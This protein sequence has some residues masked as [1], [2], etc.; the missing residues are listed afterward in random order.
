VN[1]TND[2]THRWGEPEI[3]VN[4]KNP[5]NLVYIVMSDMLTYACEN[6]GDPNCVVS[7]G[8]PVGLF[9]V[10]G[11]IDASVFVSFDRGRSWKNASFPGYPPGQSNLLSKGDPMVT[12][13]S[14]GT[15]YIGW[16]D[17]QLVGAIAGGIAVSRSTDGGLTWSEPTLTG[18]PI[19][20]PWMVAD[21][22]TGTIYEASGSPSQL[23]PL[24][25]G[26]PSSPV[27]T[28]S[29]RWLVSSNDGSTWTTPEGLG[30][31]SGGVYYSGGFGGLSAAKGVLASA[32]RSTSSASC[33]FFVSATAP[34]TVF[35][36]TTDS[37]VTWSRHPLPVPSDSTGTVMVAADPTTAGHFT[38]G[39]LNATAGEFLVY[40]TTDTGATWSGPAVVTEDATLTHQRPWMAYSPDGVLGL[41]WRTNQAGA[42]PTFPYNVWAAISGDG[43]ATFSQPLEISTS[44]SP[45]PDPAYLGSDDFS[46][47]TLS[48][49]AAFIGWADW[50]PGDR[51]G[52]VSA[53]K[54][55]AFNP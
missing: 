24:S 30:G 22:S 28:I 35:E 37:G 10:P 32:F 40:Q 49:Q 52:L 55:Q 53:V 19:D 18:T 34:C 45:A 41:M 42:G 31:S 50:H 2:L 8:R 21:L 36:T 16:D 6:A 20:R 4:P 44:T 25:T 13:T 7:G 51:S 9:T 48:R 43:G 14:N 11:W 29:D 47:I 15:F 39:V 17:M 12:V 46:Y 27:G 5:N 38:V 3:A 33:E 54:L 26:D 1:V 23:G